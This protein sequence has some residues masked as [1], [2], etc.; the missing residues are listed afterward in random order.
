MSAIQTCLPGFETYWLPETAAPPKSTF[1]PHPH[2]LA[3][4]QNYFLG[5]AA[6]GRTIYPKRKT[7]AAKLEMSVRNLARYLRHLSEVGWMKTLER[8]AYTAIRSV[9]QALGVGHVPSHVPCSKE[10][11][12]E[13]VLLREVAKQTVRV[14]SVPAL[15]PKPKQERPAPIPIKP[16]WTINEFGRQVLDPVWSRINS[17]L[18]EAQDRIRRAR[19]PEAYQQAIVRAELP[20]DSV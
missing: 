3:R 15:P 2:T 16:P 6:H 14:C 9:L 7:V 10:T 19:N 13:T 4:V 12:E 8:K 11:S 17:V 20:P 1:N 5:Y 18:R